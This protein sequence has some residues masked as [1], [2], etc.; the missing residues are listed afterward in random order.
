MEEKDC[1]DRF[2]VSGKIEDY[3]K[4][5]ST[6]DYTA[7][8]NADTADMGDNVERNSYTYRDGSGLIPS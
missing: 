2:T 8:N 7:H 4:Y 5:R 1:W 6:V 3:L